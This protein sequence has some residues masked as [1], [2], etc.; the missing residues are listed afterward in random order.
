MGC[1]SNTPKKL[2]SALCELMLGIIDAICKH[3]GFKKGSFYH[4]YPDKAALALEAFEYFRKAHS[5]PWMD[6]AFSPWSKE[7]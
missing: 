7:P 6:G 1:T 2:Q 3:A 4:A 5:R